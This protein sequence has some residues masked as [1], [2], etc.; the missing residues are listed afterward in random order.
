[1]TMPMTAEDIVVGILYYLKQHS[2]SRITADRESLHRAFYTA[3]IKFPNMLATFTFRE[4]E[5]F[6]ESEQ[7]DQALSNLDAAGLISRLNLTPRYY[8]FESALNSS[9]DKFSSKILRDNGIG[10]IQI[11][12]VACEIKEIVKPL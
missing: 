6:P 12:E 10:E 5:Q 7:L 8:C 4:R 3:K 9:Y 1:M 2:M 11:A